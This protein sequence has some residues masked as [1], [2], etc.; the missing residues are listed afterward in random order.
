MLLSPDGAKQ[1][2]DF[3][4]FLDSNIAKEAGRLFGWSEKFWSRRYEV[5][6]VSDEEQAQVSR[7]KYIL[8]NSCKEGLVESP[9]DWMGANVAAA[10][11]NGENTLFG[12]WFDRTQE[13]RSRR[14]GKPELFPSV[15]SVTLSPLPCWAHLDGEEIRRLVADLVEEIEDETAT[16]HEEHGTSP[17]GMAVVLR[18][19]AHDCPQ[20]LKRS[21]APLFHAATRK[22][23]QAMR[24]AYDTFLANYREAAKRLKAGDLHAQFPPA[25]FPPPRPY[26]ALAPG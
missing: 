15:E 14:A 26:M 7:L 21:P 17:L 13:Y 22:A 16:M 10:F 11:M 9:L 24:E 2:A 5:V 18:R 20:L 3:M 8:S 4:R 19:H 25:C 6:L 1:L 23:L 12:R